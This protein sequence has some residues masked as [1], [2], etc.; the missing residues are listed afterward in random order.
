MTDEEDPRTP[1]TTGDISVLNYD[2]QDW[3]VYSSLMIN[4]KSTMY[5]QDGT[6]SIGNYGTGYARISYIT[7]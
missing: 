2:D 4:G 1:K 6:S 3:K 5:L 7:H